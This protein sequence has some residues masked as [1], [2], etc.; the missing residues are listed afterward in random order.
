[1]VAEFMN[2]NKIKQFILQLSAEAGDFLRNHFYTFKN[3]YQKDIGKLVTNVD[4]DLE[5]IIVRRIQKEYPEHGIIVHGSKKYNED[6]KNAW[7]VD[8][9]DGSSHYARSIPIYTVNIA[10]QRNGETFF[11]AVNHAQTRQLFFAE[12]GGGAF[13]N[14]IDIHVSE[15][16]DIA[17][18]YVYIELPEKK[19]SKQKGFQEN[20]DM[21]LRRVHE[22]IQN[23][24]QVETFRIGA[25]G[26]CLVAAGAF[27]AYVDLS[28]SS[29]VQSQSASQ[30][31]VKEA[32]G[33][34]IDIAPARDGFV[35]VIASNGNL[36]GVLLDILNKE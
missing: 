29:Q 13:L 36:E 11:G 19:F 35:Q 17:K 30:L 18:A 5:E 23:V 1:M 20:F 27:D 33:Q 12:K 26:Q 34:I 25:F 15:E 21:N 24:G 9:L 22:L 10:F 4:L 8:A 31:I 28:G 3:V 32:G 7:I 6:A 14:G 16:S 2:V